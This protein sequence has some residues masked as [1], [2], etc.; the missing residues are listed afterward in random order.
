MKRTGSLGSYSATLQDIVTRADAVQMPDMYITDAELTALRELQKLISEG[1][2]IIT[3]PEYKTPT[4]APLT[5]DDA[6][7][8][9]DLLKHARHCVEHVRAR[10]DFQTDDKITGMYARSLA[11]GVMNISEK[12]ETYAEDVLLLKD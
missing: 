2:L 7:G 10:L 9:Y 12:L 6:W 11:R 4:T 8:L 5:N 1:S 3:A